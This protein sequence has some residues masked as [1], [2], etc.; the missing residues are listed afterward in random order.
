MIR[1]KDH[2][3]QALIILY[4]AID[5]LAWGRRATGDVTRADFC[6]WVDQYM[7]PEKNL[8]CTAMDLYGARCGLLHSGVAESRKSRQG[9]ASEIWYG[10]SPEA[11]DNL[12]KRVQDVKQDVKV[13]Y[14]TDL[15]AVFMEVSQ[16]FSNE[17]T[18]D[19]TRQAEV[20]ERVRRWVRFI[21]HS[22]EVDS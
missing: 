7:E 13:V 2:Y 6:N 18:L 12:N 20:S 1:E 15:I 17:I 11:T 19:V 9:Q 16:R 8:G 22:T 5:T 3:L 4:A 10:T 21:P 14:F